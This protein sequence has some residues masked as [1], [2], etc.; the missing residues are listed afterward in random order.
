[1]LVKRMIYDWNIS[2]TKLL[3]DAQKLDK[4]REFKPKLFA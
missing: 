1:M 2:K 3:L 4:K